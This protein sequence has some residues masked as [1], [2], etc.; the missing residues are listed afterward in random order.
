MTEVAELL[1]PNTEDIQDKDDANLK[2]E[3]LEDQKM[4]FGIFL[5]KLEHEFKDI[6]MSSVKNVIGRK[7]LMQNQK[8]LRLILVFDVLKLTINLK[9][10]I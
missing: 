5:Q 4:M 6:M 9:K 3:S 1:M 10:N 7:R 8:N 2:K